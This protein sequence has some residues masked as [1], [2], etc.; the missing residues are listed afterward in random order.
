MGRGRVWQAIWDW[1]QPVHQRGVISASQRARPSARSVV[2][3]STEFGYLPGG[4]TGEAILGTAVEEGE[5][6]DFLCADLDPVPADPVFRK[7]LREELWQMV[8]D[9]RLAPP[10]DS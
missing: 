8:A 6:L 1:F 3:V 5:L 10:K 4:T 9:G 2:D 7:R